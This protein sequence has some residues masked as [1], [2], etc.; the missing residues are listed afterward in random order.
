[1]FKS[2]N[3]FGK[4]D[5]IRS[6]I[7]HMNFAV[8]GKIEY[9][10]RTACGALRRPVPASRAAVAQA[11]FDDTHDHLQGCED[12]GQVP[13]VPLA[14]GHQIHRLRQSTDARAAAMR[15]RGFDTAVR[16]VLGHQ[17]VYR[18]A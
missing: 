10:Y 18:G 1:V 8:S 17:L 7:P 5:V 14:P 2:V 4:N 9:R 3:S 11:A 13:L 6:T 12:E 16:R 15:N